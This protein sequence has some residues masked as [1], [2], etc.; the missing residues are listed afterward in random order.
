[1]PYFHNEKLRTALADYAHEAW[2]DRMRYMFTKGIPNT[3]GSF[4]IDADSVIR[5]TRQVDTL[6]DDLPPEERR[7]DY[8]EADKMLAIVERHFESVKEQPTSESQSE[9]RDDH[10][11]DRVF[12]EEL[13]DYYDGNVDD[14]PCDTPTLMKRLRSI[15]IG[16]DQLKLEQ[17]RLGKLEEQVDA[18][19]CSRIETWT[20]KKQG[21]MDIDHIRIDVECAQVAATWLLS[22]RTQAAGGKAMLGGG[23]GALGAAAIGSMF[24]SEPK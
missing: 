7:S 3:D 13:A 1:M 19:L 2:S 24:R 6:F 11:E 18:A 8:A 23:L 16:C 15:A 9:D 22:R 10:S 5:W 14:R 12:L 4:S 20:E 17:Q 21:A